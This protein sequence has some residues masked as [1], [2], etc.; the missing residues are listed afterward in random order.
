MKERSLGGP[1]SATGNIKFDT[2]S[3]IVYPSDCGGASGAQAVA[4]RA[5][6]RGGNE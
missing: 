3:C 4:V 5:V 6:G 2:P 1:P